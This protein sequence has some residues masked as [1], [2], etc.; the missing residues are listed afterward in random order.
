MSDPRTVA[1]AVLAACSDAQPIVTIALPLAP[2][3]VTAT[4]IFVIDRA[5]DI[6]VASATVPPS[7]SDVELGVPAERTL[8]FTVLA[9]TAEVGPPELGGQMP[10]Y[11]G[12]VERQIPLGREQVVLP[13]AAHAAGALTLDPSIDPSIGDIVEASLEGDAGE[14][15]IRIRFDP[16]RRRPR[17]LAARVGRYRVTI[18][19]ASEKEAVI[20]GGEG[21]F[22]ERRTESIGV[23]AIAPVPPFLPPRAPVL[24]E[25]E[26]RSGGAIVEPPIRTGTTALSLEVRVRAE[27]S[28]GARADDP[29]AE[30]EV[31][32]ETFPSGLVV[33]RRL[34][35]TGLPAIFPAFD[36]RGT[37]RITIRV[38]ARTLGQ[39]LRAE[40]RSNVL[41]A[42]D[43]PGTAQRLDLTLDDLDI[44]VGGTE[45]AVELLDRRGLYAADT[46]AVGFED[47]DPFLY[48]PDGPEAA[49]GKRGH[50]LWPI[51]R[52]SSPRGLF[53]V[54][55]ATFT[56]TAVP[57]TLTA[58]VALPAV[59]S[60]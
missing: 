3:G 12:R 57:G 36:T 13:I 34:S 29:R 58:S 22:V 44:P 6:V 2:E 42:A 30:V 17:V 7:A 60:M 52:P 14:P 16:E 18:A 1:L 26:L 25:I 55:R 49:I 4:S 43:E 41:A 53:V 23:F 37:G 10:G 31:D 51:A 27:D 28:T 39:T 35:T 47:S 20:V 56:S 11:I 32:V 15:P 50:I 5:R 8:L 21:F 48:F 9:R 38:A 24:L 54:L 46:G 19:D 33:G 45:L 59:E 40:L